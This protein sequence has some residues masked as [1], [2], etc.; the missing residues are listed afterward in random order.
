[1]KR[2]ILTIRRRRVLNNSNK[3]DISLVDLNFIN[4]ETPI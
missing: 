1:M 3:K 2:V 4:K